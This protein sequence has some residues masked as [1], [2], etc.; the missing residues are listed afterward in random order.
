MIRLTFSVDGKI[1]GSSYLKKNIFSVLLLRVA[2]HNTV[3]G[4]LVL[5][6]LDRDT[7]SRFA[8]LSALEGKFCRKRNVKPNHILL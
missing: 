7:G 6:V 5:H 3:E 2:F 1:K 4:L 8:V